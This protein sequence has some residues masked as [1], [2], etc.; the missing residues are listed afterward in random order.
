MQTE[1]YCPSEA[2]HRVQS[3]PFA[4]RNIPA[5]PAKHPAQAAGST[6]R[7]TV[8]LSSSIFNL[9]LHYLTPDH[10]ARNRIADDFNY[11]LLLARQTCFSSRLSP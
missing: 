10:R 5:R 4:T 11:G 9:E 6:V 1:A 2:S 3:R 7:G 8:V